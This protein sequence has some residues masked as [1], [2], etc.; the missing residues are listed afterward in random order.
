[1]HEFP[2]PHLQP[3]RFVKKLIKATTQD[4]SVIV[5]FQTIPTLGMF[6]EAAAQSA[7]GIMN[8]DIKGNSGFL[9]TLKNIKL[10]QT[11]HKLKYHVDI[12][13]EHKMQNFMFLNF[14]ILDSELPIVT[15]SLVVSI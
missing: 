11:P 7:S 1:M 6:V 3:I 14:N 2:I 15:G 8:S 9:I 12:V 13:L 10:L 5:E 4:A